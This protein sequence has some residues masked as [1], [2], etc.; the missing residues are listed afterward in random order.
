VL[1]AVGAFVA[2]L[3]SGRIL[4]TRVQRRHRATA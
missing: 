4:A 3:V 1:V 2:L